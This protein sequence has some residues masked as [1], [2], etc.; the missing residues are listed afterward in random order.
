[1]SMEQTT[2]TLLLDAEEAQLEMLRQKVGCKYNKG[3][4]CGLNNP[5]KCK[6]CG[7]NP[8][9]TKLTPAQPWLT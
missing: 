5:A 3:V 2:S 1:M 7:W 8:N 9:A 4:I 6:R